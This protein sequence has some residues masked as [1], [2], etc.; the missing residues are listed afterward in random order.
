MMTKM[1]QASLI[2]KLNLLEKESSSKISTLEE[3]NNQMKQQIRNLES[4]NKELKESLSSKISLLSKE[5]EQIKQQLNELKKENMVKRTEKQKTDAGITHVNKDIKSIKELKD[6]TEKDQSKNDEK[7]VKKSSQITK[8]ANPIPKYKDKF[9][10][11]RIH[12]SSCYANNLTKMKVRQK[13]NPYLI[14]RLKTQPEECAQRT[15]FCQNTF[16][17]QWSDNFDFYAFDKNEVL[18]IN[19]NNHSKI[20][21]HKP[22]MDEIEFPINSIDSSYKYVRQNFD[23]TLKDKNAGTLSFCIEIFSNIK[24]DIEPLC[25]YLASGPNSIEQKIYSC[26]TYSLI[27]DHDR[28]ICEAC[29]RKCYKNH[30]LHY[31]TFRNKYYCDC[32]GQSNCS[33]RYIKACDLQCTSIETSKRPVNQM[34]YCCKDCANN[35][36]ICQNCAIKFHYGHHL[37]CLGIVE[38]RVCQNDQI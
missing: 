25:T 10:E 7:T 32:P 4:Q 18:V 11:I 34:M 19:M 26:F 14:L 13:P 15:E 38:S 1:H 9:N 20:E 23:L 30:Y 2:Q 33:Y 31:Q 35:L 29:A 17:P 24:S 21:D 36:F 3:E 37:K 28:G 27:G 16:D 22:M 8:I 12:I 5:N 6:S